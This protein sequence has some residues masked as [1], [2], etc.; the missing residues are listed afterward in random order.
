MYR[1]T[2]RTRSGNPVGE[3]TGPTPDEAAHAAQTAALHAYGAPRWTAGLWR[4]MER[5]GFRCTVREIT[6]RDLQNHA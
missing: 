6:A 3:G 4:D 2:V 5:T 1:A